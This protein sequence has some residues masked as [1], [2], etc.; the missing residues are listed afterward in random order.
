YTNW[1]SGEP[2]TS[3]YDG[4]Y[5]ASDGLWYDY[6]K[7]WTLYGLTEWTDPLG[8]S[9]AGPGSLA[10][11]LLDVTISDPV[12]PVVT[13]VSR[14]PDGGTTSQ[15]ISTFEATFS[16]ALDPSTVN[17][18]LYN[19]V[20]DSGHMY[21]LSPTT[22]NWNDARAYAQSFGGELVTIDDAT[23]DAF[24]RSTFGSAHFW[25]GLNDTVTEGTWEW[26][27]GS[28]S[29][30]RNWGSTYNDGN[31]DAVYRHSNGFWYAN[32]PSSGFRAMVEVSSLTGDTDNDGTPNEVD[33][34]P[35]DPLNG[36]DLRE[37]G[38]DGLFD[39]ADDD[40]YDLR[41]ASTYSAGTTV[42]LRVY[43]GPLHEGDFRLTV[44][45]SITDVVGNPLDGDGNGT[46]GDAYTQFFT[47][48]LEDGFVY[49]GR[50]NDSLANATPLS[51]VEDPAGRGLFVTD[52]R[53]LG[54][55]DPTYDGDWWRFEGQA[56]DRVAISA[57]TPNS[58]LRTWVGMYNSSGGNLT[59]N[60]SSGPDNDGF[61]SDYSLTSTGNYYVFV[62]RQGGSS[63][64]EYQLRIEKTQGIGLESDADYNN[65]SFSG[66]DPVTL[67][68]AGN[69][70]TGAIA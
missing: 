5:M 44:T 66:A 41:L 69:Q 56:G 30:Y 58:G 10:Q 34:H 2:S 37:A 47:V 14:L 20:I 51:L 50:D 60:A 31:Y 57:D 65:D 8:R 67:T 35:E 42:S 28:T 15:L 49:E 9:S 43:D 33:S 48:D 13:S 68:E 70:R 17:T 25:T 23:E 21:A 6:H 27:D 32:P 63:V 26:A 11:Y 4:V 3:S 64:G 62:Q 18:P 12:P 16:E 46:G 40:V 29:T 36:W 24:L 59:A 22:M 7:T 38:V 45:P 61:I 19:Y 39:T 53:G 1:A 55:I 52:Q 54:S